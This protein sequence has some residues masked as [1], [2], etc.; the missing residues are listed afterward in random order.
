M[1]KANCLGAKINYMILGTRQD[2][3]P[4]VLVHGLGAN[5]SFWYMKIAK[6]LT[7]DRQV[8]IYDL[9]GHGYSDTT[10]SG[11]DTSTMEKDLAELLRINDVKSYHLV[12]HSYG[13][14][15]CI[16]NAAKNQKS[17]KTLTIADMQLT[18]LQ[19]ILRL[20][21]WPHWQRWKKELLDNGIKT[22]PEDTSNIDFTLLQ[23]LNTLTGIRGE[24]EGKKSLKKLSLKNKA[25]TS[26][27]QLI[28]N[29]TAK[30]DFEDQSS[31]KREIITS[32]RLPILCLY[33]ELSHCLPTSKKIKELTK[34]CKYIEVENLGHFHPALNPD[35][36]II[37][38]T[39]FIK[40]IEAR[41]Q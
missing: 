19:P 38:V 37:E 13:A 2:K 9:R 24:A 32:L 20:K 18:S 25:S 5:I 7:E 26:W 41:G 12:G 3:S 30:K 16:L 27:H 8:I 10:P 28:K 6:K 1:K 36:F 23:Y 29:T 33:G 14:G 35:R 15:I 4:I 22:L 31:L 17:V 39:R 11:Y 40:D 21:E 34:D